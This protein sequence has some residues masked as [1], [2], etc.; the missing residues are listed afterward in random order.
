MK[1]KGTFAPGAG[2]ALPMLLV[3]V[4]ACASDQPEGH[5][6]RPGDAA[7]PVE[8]SDAA[9]TGDVAPTEDPVEPIVPTTLDEEPAVVEEPPH[10]GADSPTIDDGAPPADVGV[11]K[12]TPVPDR[13]A[14]IFDRVIAKPK[15]GTLVDK[16]AVRMFA[17]RTTGSPI[18]E[19]K[20]GPRGTFLIVFAPAATPRDK[21]AQQAL[22]RALSSTD[23]F[24]YVEPD[25]I[26][27]AR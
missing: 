4:A 3:V 20:A 1:E 24:E 19:V 8:P 7:A 17:E 2:R 21:V 16:D 22:V 13:N 15:K 5:P 26:M 18:G 12:P 10:S 23:Q 9:P 11:S 27:T 6:H 25:V 14:F